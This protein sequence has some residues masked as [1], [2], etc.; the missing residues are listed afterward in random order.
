MAAE[1]ILVLPD[2]FVLR[3]GTFGATLNAWAQAEVDGVTIEEDEATE[4]SSSKQ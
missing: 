2:V 3:D 1:L 4:S